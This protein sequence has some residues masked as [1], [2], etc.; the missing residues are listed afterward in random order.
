MT[1]KR[2]QKAAG[3]KQQWFFFSSLAVVT[4][5]TNIV[6]HMEVYYGLCTTANKLVI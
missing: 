4:A 6:C 1:A 3:C 2:A 5:H